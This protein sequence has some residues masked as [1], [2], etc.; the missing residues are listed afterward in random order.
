AGPLGGG[1]GPVLDP[2]VAIRCRLTLVAGE[3][4]TVGYI[5]GVAPTRPEA[6]ALIDKY[7]DRQLADRVFDL[8]QIHAKVVLRQLNATE[9]DAQLYGRLAGSIIY[10]SLYRRA[11]PAMLLKNTRGQSALWAYSISGDLPIVLVRIADSSAIDLVAKL[12]QAHAYWRLKGLA[13]D[14]VIWNEERTG[15][16]QV[17]NDR[18]VGLIAAGPEASLYD[19]TGGVFL[20]HPDQMSDEDQVLMLAAARVVFTDSGGTLGY[21]VQR[22]LRTETTIPQLYTPRRLERSDPAPENFS[23]E[24]LLFFN[25]WGGFTRDGREYIIQIKPANPTPMPWVNVVAN[26]QLGSVISQSGG[27]TWFENAHEFRLTPWYNDPVCDRSGEALYV[28]DEESAKFWSAM[29]LPAPGNGDYL[30]RHGFGYSVFEYSQYLLKSELWIYADIEAP[31]K[32]WLLKVRNDAAAPRRVSATLFLELVL[33]E[34]RSKTAMH[35]RTG[36]DSKTGALLASNPFSTEFAGRVVFFEASEVDRSIS[37]DRTEFIGRNG[38]LADPAALHRVRLSG[39]VGVGLD[40][41]AAIQA[42]FDLEPGKEKEIVFILGVGHDIEEARTLVRRFSGLQAAFDARDRVWNYWNHT[43]GAVNIRT[44]DKSL[45]LLTN[46]WLIYQTMAARLWGRSGFYQSGGAFGFRDQLQDVMA[47]LHTRPDLAR[48]HLLLCA[49]RQFTE[50]DVQHWWHPPAGRGV[51]TKIS[52]DYLWLPFVMGD[53]VARTGDNGV[54]DESV[55]FLESRRLNAD[56]E[57][58]YDLPARSPEK[59]TLYEHGKRSILH[60]LQ[61]GRHGLPLMGSGD[62]ND[63]MNLVGIKGEGESV[64]LAFFLYAVL[65]QFIP[66]ARLRDDTAFADLCSREMLRLREKIESE[67][68]DGQWYARAFF[69]DGTPLGSLQNEECK[70]DGVVQSWSVLSGAA[71]AEHTQSAMQYLARILI[72]S[73]SGIIKLLD[74]PFNKSALEPG[75]IKGYVPGVRENGGQYTHGAIW[76]IMA[77]ALMGET[78]RVKELIA[79]INPINHSLTPRSAGLYRVEPYVMAADIYGS[80]PHAGQGGWTWYTG[81]AG[82]MYRLILESVLGLQLKANTLSFKPCIPAEWEH[83]TVHYRFRETVYHCEFHQAKPD[84]EL[85]VT[86][87]GVEQENRTVI[88]SDDQQEHFVEIVIGP[89]GRV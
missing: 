74:P 76:A 1:E 78:Q 56:E 58:F 43:L 30:N 47:L 34:D 38:T 79:L 5:S 84:G 16:R 66:L 36:I 7:Q 22:A 83:F 12:I 37:G 53:Y 40:P 89:K 9:A 75:Y 77:F 61:F 63:G 54:L 45:D 44:P 35:V 33:G 4:I 39:K 14:L 41:A 73:R 82:W 80:E 29:P 6:E 32:F 65:E 23:Q 71:P 18:I 46:G 86:V 17:L 48:D 49:S 31:V 59:T 11:N 25:G 26:A 27:Y 87:D 62:W 52:D 68:W 24:N 21:Q 42:Y 51:R 13:V 28:R 20:R 69:D 88:L 50:G 19:K 85:H 8:A 3:S 70:I 10:A 55:H 64:W 72:D 67:G 57:S 2:I 81:S 15:Y 60:A